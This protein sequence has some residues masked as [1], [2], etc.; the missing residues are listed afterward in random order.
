[1][2]KKKKN[3]FQSLARWAILKTFEEYPDE[4]FSLHDLL[5]ELKRAWEDLKE[6]GIIYEPDK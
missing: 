4:V 5:E 2:K 3:K 6:E 1:M